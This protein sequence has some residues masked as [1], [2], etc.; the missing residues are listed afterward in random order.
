MDHETLAEM[1]LSTMEKQIGFRRSAA[2][3]QG[4]L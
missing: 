4:Q 3:F 2:Y 1:R